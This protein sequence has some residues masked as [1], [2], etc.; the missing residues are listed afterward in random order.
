MT[1]RSTVHGTFKIEMNIEASPEQIFQVFSDPAAKS[2]WFA[3]PPDQCTELHRE[4]D[5]RVGGKERL[6]AKW[7][8]GAHGGAVSHCDLT[9]MNIVPNERIV[10][11]YGMTIDETPLSS[12]VASIELTPSGNGTRFV[13]TEHGI[14]FDGQDGVAGREQGTR[15]L[16][17]AMRAAVASETAAAA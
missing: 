12:S 5:F 10:Y 3:G 4:M 17:E 13:L 9:Y 1:I 16:L 8:K 6:S 2:K 15:G 7:D 11:A 14:Y